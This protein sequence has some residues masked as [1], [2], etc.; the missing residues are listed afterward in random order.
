MFQELDLLTLNGKISVETCENGPRL[1]TL[2]YF[3]RG[4]FGAYV[5]RNQ[6]SVQNIDGAG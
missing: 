5:P 4:Q 3:D 6:N 1:G 2:R